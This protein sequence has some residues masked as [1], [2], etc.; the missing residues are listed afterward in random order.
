MHEWRR[1]ATGGA[2]QDSMSALAGILLA[3]A[4]IEI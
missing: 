3:F 2:E 4:A 1:L